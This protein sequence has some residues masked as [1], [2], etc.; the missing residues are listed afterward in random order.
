MSPREAEDWLRL[1]PSYKGR[2][3][4]R[5]ALAKEQEQGKEFVIRKRGPSGRPLHLFTRELIRRHLPEFWQHR[6]DRVASRAESAVRQIR[7]HIDA[8]ID[9]RI[10]Q[11]PTVRGLVAQADETIDL[12][13]SLAVEVNRMTGRGAQGATRCT[14][15][16][17][18]AAERNPRPGDS[19]RDDVG[20]AS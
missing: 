3:F 18:K 12:V 19:A 9:E 2:S 1:K 8:H 15:K 13:E 20:S 16:K 14:E 6:F 17:M 7:D 10:D 11:H 5:A 4:L